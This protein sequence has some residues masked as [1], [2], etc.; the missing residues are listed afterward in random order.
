MRILRTRPRTGVLQQNRYLGALIAPLK[1]KFFHSFRGFTEDSGLIF[2][3]A[4]K[5]QVLQNRKIEVAEPAIEG[6]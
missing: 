2:E 3:I 4:A 1:G 6:R 5:P